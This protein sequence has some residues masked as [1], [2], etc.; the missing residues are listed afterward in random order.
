MNSSLYLSSQSPRRAQLL[1][2]IGVSFELLLAQPGED[3]E[4]LEIVLPNEAPSAYAIR[5]TQLKAQAGVARMLAQG[6]P[7]KPVLTADTVVA[8]GGQIFGKPQDADDAVRILKSLSGASHHVFTAVTVA[9][10]IMSKTLLSKNR[11][12]FARLSKAQIDQYIASG[13]CFGKAG[14]YG[15]QGKAATFIRDLQGSYSGVMGLPLFETQLLLNRFGIA[16]PK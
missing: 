7:T 14:A 5:V 4:S 10:P 16:L 13:E 6:L 11:L 9:L 8:R 15:I 2:Q 1:E 3:P 12:R